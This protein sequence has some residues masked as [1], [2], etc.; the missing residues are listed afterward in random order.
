VCRA[1]K[2]RPPKWG[3]LFLPSAIFSPFKSLRAVTPT[4]PTRI[5]LNMCLFEDVVVLSLRPPASLLCFSSVSMVRLISQLYHR[6][7]GGTGLLGCFRYYLRGT[8][9][10]LE[11]AV[12]SADY[13]T[14]PGAP[15]FITPRRLSR[16][17]RAPDLPLVSCSKDLVFLAT[18]HTNSCNEASNL[19]S[20]CLFL[21]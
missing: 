6:F 15:N 3:R 10:F 8:F 4:L 16:F 11:F 17:P 21:I 19:L 18:P 2:K 20:F 12:D 14:R 1:S 13:P 9:S 5:L 7:M